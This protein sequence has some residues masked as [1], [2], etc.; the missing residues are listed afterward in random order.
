MTAIQWFPDGMENMTGADWYLLLSL[1]GII[2]LIPMGIEHLEKRW[3][4]KK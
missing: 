1:V 3:R 2:C 4:N